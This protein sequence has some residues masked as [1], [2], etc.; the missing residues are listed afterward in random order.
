MS[1]LLA[2]TTCLPLAQRGG[3]ELARDALAAADQFDHHV[4]VG[5]IRE[6]RRIGLEAN[7]CEVDPARRASDRARTTATTASGRPPR[8]ASSSA[9][10]RSR[11]NVPAPTV[12]SPAMAILSGWLT[13][14]ARPW[15]SWAVPSVCSLRVAKLRQFCP[16]R[17]RQCT[18]NTS[19]PV[20]AA[21]SAR[22]GAAST[23]MRPRRHAVR[24]Q[25]RCHGFGAFEREIEAVELFLHRVIAAGRRGMADDA[26]RRRH[27][28][29][30]SR[31]HR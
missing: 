9:F 6:R 27:R 2:V 16:C 13:E 20:A 17:A 26:E 28:G 23:A 31:R 5:G 22:V 14:G 11:R 1:A 18:R 10:C 24:A 15:P 19:A 29:A 3:D 8:C 4:D 25:R 7:G 21:S 30:A 12:P